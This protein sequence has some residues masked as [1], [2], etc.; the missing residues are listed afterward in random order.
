[1]KA[2]RLAG[3][4]R[5]ELLDA[6]AP[7]AKDGECLVRME[8]LS[9]CGSDI[10]REYALGRPE[11]EY[12]RRLGA[13]CHECAG[14]V[15]ESRTDAYHEGQRV[16][17]LPTS[18]AGGG[19]GGLV[20]FMTATPPN[21]IGVPDSG[22]L[23]EWVMCQPV[24][25]VLYAY[26]RLGSV[27]GKN[28]VVVGQ[29]SIGLSFVMLAMRSGA[30]QVIGVDRLDYRLR[31]AESLGA[32]HTINCDTTDTVQA[33][34]DLTGGQGA[35]VVVE[36]TGDQEA[37]QLS[38]ALVRPFGSVV[39]FGIQLDP[40]VPMDLN[41]LLYKQPT[42]I[43]TANTFS[44]DPAKVV[45]EMVELKERGWIDPGRL[46]THRVG[47]QEVQRAYDMYE[48]QQDEVIKVVLTV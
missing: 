3:H 40:I 1:M 14:T 26:Q 19:P 18:E 12:P 2:A 30:R 17:V 6:E 13:P 27:L 25:T 36:A 38:L 9:V 42:I 35:D 39:L 44:A 16:I 8:R 37:V 11:E 45:R 28:V 4:R 5:F 34:Y 22:D 21:L 41:M 47:L 23:A 24:G 10:H 46:V 15:V 48:H 33:V 7:T 20:E 32:A 29:G 43:P 31:W